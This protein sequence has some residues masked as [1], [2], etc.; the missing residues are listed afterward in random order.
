MHRLLPS[1]IAA[2]F[3]VSLASSAHAQAEV[4]HDFSASV[5]STGIERIIVEMP[6]AGITIRT[7]Q[8]SEISL[9][10][11]ARRGFRNEKQRKDA[12]VMVDDSSIEVV[13]DGTTAVIKRAFGP[14]AKSRTARGSKTRFEFSITIPESIGVRIRMSGGEIDA[15]GAIGH[16]DIGLRAGDVKL[17]MPRSSVK[18]LIARA[19]IGDLHLNLG[20]RIVEKEG[21]L[22]GKVNYLNEGGSHVVSVLVTTGDITIELTR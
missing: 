19:R 5:P 18:E 13:V 6:E 22:A 3:A 15:A 4:A 9:T 17:V 11:H 20:D 10:G 21:V 7:T 8:T 12:Q 1:L 16:I 2:T 14:R